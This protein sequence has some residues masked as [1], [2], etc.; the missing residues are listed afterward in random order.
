[1]SKINSR[2]FRQYDEDDD[3][4]YKKGVRCILFDL[5]NTIA[6]PH[7]KKPTKRLK[8]LFDELN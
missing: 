7:A 6:P 5:D 1:M 8:K 2:I 3:K 4:L